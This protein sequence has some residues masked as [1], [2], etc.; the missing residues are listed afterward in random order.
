MRYVRR[1]KF[2][3]KRRSVYAKYRVANKNESNVSS[4][5]EDEHSQEYIS[6]RRDSAVTEP[7]KNEETEKEE[8][9]E[10][11]P[12]TPKSPSKQPTF[13]Q[14]TI[15]QFLKKIPSADEK[16][17]PEAVPEVKEPEE[18][19]QDATADNNEEFRLP[20]RTKR[21]SNAAHVSKSE[22]DLAKLANG[23]GGDTLKKPIRE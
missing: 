23:T 1:R 3:R 9:E 16:R 6:R 14:L 13:K 19:R 4:H 8:E 22:T 10:K 21:L 12:V 15:D 18:S 11:Q 5:P 20:R 2:G 17:E 7:A